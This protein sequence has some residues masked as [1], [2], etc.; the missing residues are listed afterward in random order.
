M[1]VNSFDNYELSWK[2]DRSRIEPPLYLG[3]ASMLE[4]DILSGALSSGTKMPPQRELA[5]YLDVSLNTITRVYTLCVKKGL[6]RAVTGRGTFVSGTMPAGRNVIEPGSGTGRALALDIATPVFTG[7]E[8]LLQLIREVLDSPE[9]AGFFRYT[10]PLGTT[11]QRAAAARWLELF[12]ISAG[13]ER[14]LITNGTQNALNLT[15][16]ALFSDGDRIAVDRYTYAN[17]IGLANMLNITLV[18]VGGDSS[19][20][21]AAELERLLRTVP[22]K[23]IYLSPSCSNPQALC[24]PMERRQ[25]LAAV[26]SGHGLMLIEDDC[27]AFLRGE[28]LT[29]LSVL[30]P[31]N[32]IYLSGVNKAIA[33]GLRIAFMH[34]PLRLKETL[35]SA[36][37]NCNLVA[38]PL[39]AEIARRIIESGLH[40]R[41]IRRQRE[42]VGRRSAIYAE[43]F[44]LTNPCSCYQWLPLPDGVTGR[45]FEALAAKEGVRV[46]GSERFLAGDADGRHYLRVSTAA[47][48]SEGELR[49][50]LRTVRR[51]ISELSPE[52]PH[53]YTL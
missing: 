6:L 11:A 40:L 20:M 37:Y 42:L 29:P 46:Y 18:P 9:A 25:E 52:P 26:I 28:Q 3:L 50:A 35:E 33:P 36:V 47:A 38:G 22:V 32:S 12:G 27:Y 17:F 4:R 2:P 19:G 31:E 49:A 1:P 14:V 51:L 53:G 30:A 23:G 24:M 43:Y 34:Y 41:C 7:A 44:P 13:A 16:S 21:S 48:E 15:L 5:D 45:F 10:N 8:P 39:N